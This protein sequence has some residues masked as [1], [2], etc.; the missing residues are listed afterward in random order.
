M[1]LIDFNKYGRRKV[2]IEDNNKLSTITIVL[3]VFWIISFFLFITT[4]FNDFF[5][6]KSM[7]FYCLTL[8][9][10]IKILY[11]KYQDVKK[12]K[13]IVPDYYPKMFLNIDWMDY[14]LVDT[15]NQ[16]IIDSPLINLS[17]RDLKY[18]MLIIE[19]TRPNKPKLDFTI[20]TI[21]IS[22]I[23]LFI[24]N[25]SPVFQFIKL[26]GVKNVTEEYIVT[27]L[28]SIFQILNL[29]ACIFVF[30][31]MNSFYFSYVF[32]NSEKNKYEQY[33][34]KRELINFL[35]YYKNNINRD[36]NE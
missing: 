11:L 5:S 16:K 34:A 25:Y 31:I 4:A 7:I 6:Y 9:L 35:I 33:I 26:D 22:I 24:S 36:D 3:M 14:K 20:L 17:L 12:L 19:G 28:K 23:G 27:I 1:N 18:N 15:F 21:L 29:I 32:Y 10:G 30:I 2:I 8:V 13:T